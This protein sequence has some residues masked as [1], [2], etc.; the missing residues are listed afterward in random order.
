MELT[1]NFRKRYILNLLILLLAIAKPGIAKNDIFNGYAWLPQVDTINVDTIGPLPYPFKDQ[2]AFGYSKQDSINLFLNKPSNI[3]YEIEYDPI[4]RQY[5]F[6][7]KIGNLNY[8]LPQTMSLNDYIDFDFEQ[9]VKNYW[10][11]RTRIQDLDSK[12]GLLL[13]LLT[14]G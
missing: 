5:V 7:E 9:S 4:T 14:L 1:Q 6:Y 12:G 10:K 3:K 13:Q 11:E 8:R 2:P